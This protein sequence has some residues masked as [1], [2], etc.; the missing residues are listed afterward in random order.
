[1]K[2]K[3]IRIA[4]LVILTVGIGLTNY[5]TSFVSERETEALQALETAELNTGLLS[6]APASAAVS[7]KTLLPS[8]A[9]E[10]TDYRTRLEALDQELDKNHETEQRSTTGYAAKARLENELKLW[11]AELDQILDILEDILA[12][13]E[14]DELLK[15][16]QTWL[17]TRESRA[18]TASGRQQKN[19]SEELEY[20]RSQLTDT[21]SR[22][23][24]LAE[25]YATHLNT[26]E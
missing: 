17:R 7:A 9:P 24:E 21:R 16:Q 25:E 20:T 23:Y 15:D 4:I 26:T 2:N 5:T 8:E 13:P 10:S 12:G 3:R 14:L 22:A 19:A 6:D 18:L 11:Q 1:M